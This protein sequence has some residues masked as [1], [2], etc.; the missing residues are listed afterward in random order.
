M[1][2]KKEM[3]ILGMGLLVFWIGISI[4]QE[5]G[6]KAELTGTVKG[7]LL[8]RGSRQ[9]L[10]GAEVQLSGSDRKTLTDDQGHYAFTEVPVGRY[11]LV[12]RLIGMEPMVKTDVIVK[13][14][15]TTFVAAEIDLLPVVNETVRVTAGYFDRPREEPVNSVS[16]D[17]EEI[18]RAAGAGG[19]VN[20]IITAMPSIARTND[21]ANNLAVRGGSS[22]E[23]LVLVDNIEI[24]NI[25]HFPTPGSTSGPICLLNLDLIR[26]VDFQAGGFSSRYGD[27]LSAVMDLALREGDRERLRGQTSFDMAGIAFLAE[28]PLPGKSGSW[29]ASVRRSYI[30]LLSRLMKAGADVRY[31]DVNM[32]IGFDLSA[33][34]KL[35]FIGVMG[36]DRSEVDRSQAIE[37]GEG[38]FGTMN[39]REGTWGV[40]WFWMPDD[41]W[42]ANTSFSLT[43]TSGGNHWLKTVTGEID[44]DGTARQRIWHLRHGHHWTIG[45]GQSIQMGLESKWTE[46]RFD[47][48]MG[49]AVSPL[50]QPLPEVHQSKRTDHFRHGV[51][52]EY[53]A[54]LSRRW[55]VNLGIRAD[56]N[57]YNRRWPIS[58][59]ASMRHEIDPRTAIGI[60]A[61]IY[62]QSLPQLLIARDPANASMQEPMAVQYGTNLQRL[63]SPSLRLTIEAYWKEYRHLPVDPRYPSQ[64]ILDD[65]FGHTLFG[66]GPLLDSGRAR[67]YGIEFVLQKKLKQNIYGMICGSFFRSRY[68][69]PEGQ[70]VD[71][72]Y[73]NRYIL[74]LQGGYKPDSIWEFS[75]SWILAGGIP[76]SPFDLDASK[77]ARSGIYDSSRIHSERL[78]PYHSLS[79]RSDRRFHFRRSNLTAYLSIWN[80]YNRKN[81]AS[82]YWNEITNEP[83]YIYQFSILP[84]LGIEF[85]F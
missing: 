70:W 52:A 40:N 2:K 13:S 53:S 24:P 83:G 42:Y 41:R 63:L 47:F 79:I 1:N 14:N 7:E 60:Y 59:R 58:P 68:C 22:S 50:G 46:D 30:D 9:R 44:F 54:A 45:A 8:V 37:V 29:I 57:S 71:R 80:L 82:Y 10:P 55:S 23:N 81:A 73:D 15:A 3:R 6:K 43:A 17:N 18:R 27:R 65:T 39:S 21:Q 77:A 78:P 69:S 32:K 56:G 28:G 33:R 76:Y 19:D 25:N 84:V 61:G 64:S 48:F 51:F 35:T 38:D 20:R 4:A 66:A 5:A 75:A 31:G 16:F 11:T 72:L 12:F 67:S 74:S 36:D 49:A 34:S 62:R 26:D 85:E